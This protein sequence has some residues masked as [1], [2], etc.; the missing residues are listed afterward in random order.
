MSRCWRSIRCNARR[1]ISVS[2]S[3][4]HNLHQ[5]C[6]FEADRAPGVTAGDARSRGDLVHAHDPAYVGVRGDQDLRARGR[7]E[8]AAH[9]VVV[10][11]ADEPE[12]ARNVAVTI[13][14]EE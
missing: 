13:G 7:L 8:L 1:R 6:A 5:R 14:R 9:A 4:T 2:G 10:A 11:D 3:A 12:P